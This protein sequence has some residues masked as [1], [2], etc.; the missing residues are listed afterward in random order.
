MSL[1][2]NKADREE[3]PETAE[4]SHRKPPLFYTKIVLSTMHPVFKKKQA[5]SLILFIL[6][7]SA[8]PVQGVTYNFTAC[9]QTGKT[10]P[11]QGQCDTEYSG[12]TLQGLVTVTGGIQNWTVPSTGTYTIKA[13][14]ARGGN[15]TYDT[16][17][18]GG[19]GAC[20]QGDFSLTGGEIVFLLVGQRGENTRQQVDNAA[21]GGGGGTFVYTNIS[22]T[23]P[24]IAA[25]G[26]IPHPSHRRS[27]PAPRR[28]FRLQAR[29]GRSIRPAAR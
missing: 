20:I 1:A 2:I 21:P 24:L 18:A 14:G 5:L 9:S 27:I 4:I 17:Y 16:G 13:C 6:L 3:R 11:S 10:G 25:G 22:A 19:K 29:G 12:T 15:Q 28:S 8:A 26:G 23:Y 7:L